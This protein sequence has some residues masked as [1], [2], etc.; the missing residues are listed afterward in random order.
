M[1]DQSIVV[2]L[3]GRRVDAPGAPPRFPEERIPTVRRAIEKQ[4]RSL[5]AGTLVSAAACGANLVA[6]E[7]ASALGLRIRIVLPFAPATFRT[8]SVMDR[9]GDW[10]R[11]FDAALEKARMADDLVVLDGGHDAGDE[12]YLRGGE[13]ILDQPKP[14]RGTGRW[15]PSWFGTVAHATGAT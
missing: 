10:A 1:K 4:F 12:A 14:S 5:S 3:A 11:R 2:A 13:G 6:I 9:P 7:V 15:S 8:T